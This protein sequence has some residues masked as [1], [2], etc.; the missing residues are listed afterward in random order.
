MSRAKF[1]EIS[2]RSRSRA[3]KQEEAMVVSQP[4]FAT[5]FEVTAKVHRF[6]IGARRGK[7]I[8]TTDELVRRKVK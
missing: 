7:A 4:P 5:E 1:G 2:V 3:A 8:Q 6:T